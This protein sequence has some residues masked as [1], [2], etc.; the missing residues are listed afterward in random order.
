[1]SDRDAI[2]IGGGV[3]GLSVAWWLG[4]AG[5]ASEVWEQDG[6]LGGKIATREADGYVTERA[7]SLMLNFRP[8]VSRML[9]ASGLDAS[10]VM[11]PG[12]PANQRYLVQRGKLVPVPS[13][14]GGLIRSPLWSLGGKLRLLAEPFAPRG[15]RPDE[16]VSEFVSRRLGRELLEKAMEPYIGG[17]LA[18]DPDLAS[19]QAVLPRLV[20]LERRYGS[21]AFGVFAHKVLNR[22]TAPVHEVFSFRRGM[23]DLID[24]LASAP[25]VSFRTRHTVTQLE[26]ARS[27][28]RVTARTPEGERTF[29]ASHI[30][31]S[32]PAPRAATLL[33]SLD[34][35]LAQLLR[36][37]E[38]A[39]VTVV[40]L[41]FDRAAVRHPLIGTGFL[42]PR[43]E[44]A[45]LTGCQWVSNVFP[46]R[47]PLGKTLLAC[48][49][50]GARA[51]ETR[52]WND[53]RCID[54]AI[55]GLAP[56]LGIDAAPEQV[57]VDRHD[58]ALP[59]YHGA[60][61][62]RLRAIM[63][64]LKRWPGL[65]LAANYRGGISIRDRIGEAYALAQSMHV[66][67]APRGARWPVAGLPSLPICAA[68]RSSS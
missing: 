21:L 47:A 41:A 60:Y 57:W 30:V 42:V 7:A 27:G 40:H 9:T 6:R 38:Y 8:E 19:A 4:Q 2:V 24:A 13:R 23:A 35:E 43:T 50:G 48:Y 25:G 11:C 45:Q 26:P 51:P 64:R 15:G 12:P 66:G 1:M 58:C 56:L 49:L 44:N 17:P 31:L 55:A 16:S 29:R 65:Q 37:I 32:V 39:P 61:S 14:L 34:H 63:E 28:W 3:S 20:A 46:N 59:L 52:E 36:G 67:L 68:H 22:R 5:V 54:A 10:R 18:S 33:H 62:G 53:N